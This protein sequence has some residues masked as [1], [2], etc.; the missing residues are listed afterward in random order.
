MPIGLTDEQEQKRTTAPITPRKH[1][2][3]AVVGELATSGPI[4]I[5]RLVETLI[6]DAHEARAS[7]IHLDPNAAR[8]SPPS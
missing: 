4:A 5:I 7:D 6:A 3:A 1:P 2:G 8:S